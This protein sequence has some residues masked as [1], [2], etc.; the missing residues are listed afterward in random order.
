MN[1][2]ALQDAFNLFTE[3]G[4]NGT[5]D[6]YKELIKTNEDAFNDSYGLF[7]NSGYN[8]SQNDFSSLMGLETAKTQ[9]SA[10]ADPIVESQNDT[11]SK[12]ENGL[13]ESVDASDFENTQEKNTYIEDIFGKNEF[14]DFVGDIYRA[15]DTGWTAGASVDEAFDIY[16]GKEAT[17][18]DVKD[19]L[20]KTRDMEAKG[21]TDEMIAASQKMAE[22]RDKGYNGLSAFLGGWWDN[23]S[24]MLQYTAMSMGQMVSAAVDSEEVLG[25]AA[26]TAG[27]SA[28]VGAG[29]G[30]IV[31]GIGTAIGAKVGAGAGFFAGLSGAMET[32]MTTAALI[33][34][35]AVEDGLDWSKMSD[36]KRFDYIRKLQNDEEGF[37]DI[38]SRALARGVSIGAIDGITGILTAG[39]G[40]AVF[41]GVSKGARSG[42]AN[43]ARVGASAAV[44]TAGG[45]ASEVAGQAAAGQEFNLEEVLIEGFAD[46]TFTSIEIANAIK[47]GSPKYTVNKKQ[48]NGK[49]FID[50]IKIMSDE[51]IV[52][53][54]IQIENSPAVQKLIDN[55]RQNIAADQKVDSRISDVDDRAEAIKIQKQINALG[56]AEGNKIKKKQLQAKIAE[57]EAKYENSEVDVDIQ[58]RQEAVANALETEF[59]K[60]FNVNYNAANEF[61]K[62]VGIKSKVYKTDL[63]YKKAIEKAFGSLPKGWDSS[64]GVFAGE[65]VTF[66]NKAKIRSQVDIATGS[67]GDISTASHE[68]LHP[69]FNA[70]IGSSK[71]QTK[72]VNK[73][74]RN[75]T[76]KQKAY[77]D[78]QIKARDISKD[79]IGIE[80]MN[81]FS[82]GIVKGEINYDKTVF[83]KI[84]DAISGFIRGS[85]GLNKDELNFKDGES[86][87]NFL[88]EYNE[89]IKAGKVSDATVS[90][91]KEAEAQSATKIK[92]AKILGE[93]QF[94]KSLSEEVSNTVKAQVLKIQEVAKEGRELAEKY[95]KEFMK[96]GKQERLEQKVLGA[97]QP[98][99]E[100]IVTNRTKALYDPIA[101]DQKRNVS[102]EDYQDSMRSDLQ[103][104]LI[105]EYNGTQDVEKFLVNRGYLR[106]NDLAKRLG[107]ETTIKASLDAVDSEGKGTIQVASDYNP[108]TTMTEIRSEE[109]RK[110]KLVDPRIILG[111]QRSK[112]YKE[113]VGDRI[114]EMEEGAFEGMSFAK[115]KDMAPEITADWWRTTVKKVITPAANLATKEIPHMQRL[116]I[117][118]ADMFIAMLPEGAI[119]EGETAREDLIGTGVG[120]PRKL[121]QAFYNKGE[122]TSKG[123]GLIPFNLKPEITKADFLATFA[124]NPDETLIKIN[125]KDPRSQAILALI[126]L[127]GQVTT[128]STV[129]ELAN[130]TGEQKADIRAGAAKIQFSQTQSIADALDNTADPNVLLNIQFSLSARDRYIVEL[131]KARPDLDPAIAVEDL[132]EWADS[133]KVKPNKLSKYKKLA[134]YWMKNGYLILPEDGYK[135]TEAIRLSENKKF[136]PY[137]FKNPDQLLQKYI[138][139]PTAKLT[140]PTKVKTFTLA[141]GVTEG[142]SIQ[143]FDVEDSREA[144]KDVRKVVDTHFGKKADPWCII[145][146]QKAPDMNDFMDFED[147]YEADDPMNPLNQADVLGL[148]KVTDELSEAWNNW[149]E[150]GDSQRQIAF[151][152]G[153]LVGFFANDQWWDRMDKPTDKLTLKKKTT[154]SKFSEIVEFNGYNKSKEYTTVG[155]IKGDINGFFEKLDV[156]KNLVEK[157]DEK[158][159]TEVN[160]YK[161]LSKYKD[162]VNGVDAEGAM[163]NHFYL[164][165]FERGPDGVP[166]HSWQF[167]GTDKEA[168]ALIAE[169]KMEI[170]ENKTE[171]RPA[172]NS[173]TKVSWVDANGNAL[174]YTLRTEV[175][176]Y[177]GRNF[178]YVADIINDKNLFDNEKAQIGME[179]YANN[180]FTKVEADPNGEFKLDD[181]MLSAYLTPEGK[182]LNKSTKIQFSKTYA[183]TTIDDATY[184]SIGRIFGLDKFDP[185]IAN[186]RK[187]NQVFDLKKGLKLADHRNVLAEMIPPELGSILSLSRALTAN[188]YRYDGFSFNF[189]GSDYKKISVNGKPASREQIERYILKIGEDYGGKLKSKAGVS[190]LSETSI[191]LRDKIFSDEGLYK[192]AKTKL[193]KTNPSL[194]YS[195]VANFKKAIK[196]GMS[197]KDIQKRLDLLATANELNKS[198]AELY[199]SILRDFI[200]LSDKASGLTEI[201]RKH[202]V[203]QMLASNSD[204]VNSFRSLSSINEVVAAKDSKAEYQL[205]HVNAMVN[206]IKDVARQVVYQSL[207]IDFKSE[208]I[209]MPKELSKLRD[210]TLTGKTSD[211]KNLETIIENEV[212][213]KK[214]KRYK[215]KGKAQ[216]SKEAASESSTSDLNKKFNTIIEDT[217]GIKAKKIISEAKGKMLARGKGRFKFFIPP[218]AD[219]FAGLLYKL[220]G[221]GDK[222][223]QQQA[224][225]KENLFDPFSRGIR[226][227]ESYKENAALIVKNLKKSIKNIPAGLKKINETGF[228]NEDAVRVYLWAKQ[229]L[230]IPGLTKEDQTELINVVNKSPKLVEFAKKLDLALGKYPEPQNDWLAGTITTDAINMINTTKRAEFLQEWQANADEIFS[231]DNLNKL[232]AAFGDNYVEAMEDMLYRMKSGRNRPSGSNKLTN[233]FMNWVND[234]VGTIMFFNTRSALLQTLSTVNFINWGDNNP[235]EAAKAF[236]NQKQFW[237]DF[238]MLFNSDFLKQRRSGLK[239]D[240]NADDIA[241]AA[242]TATN[243]AGAVKASLLKMGFLPTQMADSFAI[244]LGGASFVRN[245]F[246][247]LKKADS[248]LTDDAAM[249]QAL[250]D[251]QEIAEESQQSSRPDRIS[252]QQASPL[253]RVVLAFANTPMQY[254][255]L[256]KKAFLD[257]KNGR[258]DA[259]TNIT[260]IAYYMAVQNVIF[261]ALQSALFASMFEDDEE[262]LNN[263][264]IQMANSMLDSILRGVGVYGAIA[265]TLKNI[266]IEVKKQ[267]DKDRPDFTVAAQ[268]ALSISPPIDS[269]MRKL[270]AAGRAFSYKTTREKMKGFGLDNPAYYATGQV[271]SAA[272][273]IPLDRAIRKADNIRVALDNDTKYWQS[274]A[275]MLGYSQWDVGLV[276]TSKD[277]KKKKSKFGASIKWKKRTW[278]KKDK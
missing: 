253:G 159:R 166:M 127:Y 213:G 218:S 103:T 48:V 83:E 24:A 233:K 258:G 248:S 131:E 174:S 68:V 128:N 236:A 225:F 65:G 224:W 136:D 31:P 13:S 188:F 137:A 201:Q 57:I 176:S 178:K 241:S 275:L 112:D 214:Y 237:A 58:S 16:K 107:I 67:F 126:R 247:A 267:S 152:D 199:I 110:K 115:L 26:A 162:F 183:E 145:A 148:N 100:K 146:R 262:E 25:A 203:G 177:K 141:K 217:T 186:R 99:I 122:R 268:R 196:E 158:G 172:D 151:Q 278:G 9:D 5:F 7:K 205:E 46:K 63:G 132:F 173:G 76:S 120:V 197:D 73:F 140:D 64:T 208:A 95:G 246:K 17:D 10:A 228:T 56:T 274:I 187:G 163:E 243:K 54:D 96:S 150:Y 184:M 143:I 256:T 45:M 191:A 113:I 161:E 242:E 53:A 41:K 51:A 266:A 138:K 36:D 14:T 75:M 86:V 130:L 240:I 52:K 87:Y 66:I 111:P 135:V 28:A 27:G 252:Q 77:V 190:K 42:L 116:I 149:V 160:Y 257:L 195:K 80:T 119:L 273:N 144:Q 189:L 69:I 1:E 114:A 125:G 40:N 239:N 79:N 193:W 156:N 94:S 62:K 117:K 118:H 33:Q 232:R 221:K 38:K 21:Q 19:F 180:K 105:S 164:P 276:E 124:I 23:P 194:N 34:E 81:I 71:E 157:N 227:F 171:L 70:L 175:Y 222:G 92:D 182:N 74:R 250:L 30:S 206:V 198:I 44:E 210:K 2:Q 22:L 59:E 93:E 88:K 231:K 37:N 181:P 219:D 277:K 165:I 170:F 60:R 78:Q 134:L 209:L 6:D 220:L 72:V 229:G 89:G 84:G 254:M 91:L 202:L 85:V 97:V 147:V 123:A 43:A 272:T 142:H 32:G 12:S 133:L 102:R 35:K 260:K 155:Y 264:E 244:A 230:D 4:Y 185:W 11:G 168:R 108:D 61:G 270:M 212:D 15:W 98:V 271:V 234:S 49:K 8:G 29:V 153:K 261:T 167:K 39:A 154:G 207:P 50:A 104:M 269:K 47:T 18:Q 129:R 82:D 249:E 238:A 265:S 200:N 259:K 235:I 255:R 101:P 251:F 20:E 223:N 55:R 109:N 245:R 216:F 169:G 139:E 226:D 106:A 211:G 121:Q 3:E 215:T 179:W 263:K 192:Q 204:M 90:K